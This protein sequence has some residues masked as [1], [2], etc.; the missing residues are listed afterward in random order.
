MF[1]IH[2]IKLFLA[3]VL[4]GGALVAGRVVAVNLPPF[5]TT[6]IRFSAVSLF[7]VPVLYFRR[8]SFPRPSKKAAILL[9][10]L[11]FTGVLLF[12]F[13]LFSGLRTVTAVR[14]SVIIAFTPAVVALV[15][16]LFF[17]EKIRP[18]MGLGILAAFIGAVITIT[19]GELQ[20]IF[21]RALSV[22]DLF[23]LGCVF[24]WTIYS[25]TAKYAMAELAPLTVLT[26][27]SVIG[28]VLL[29]PFALT[30]G[31]LVDLGS[32]PPETWISLLYLS[33]GA[34]GIA[35]LFYYEGIQA[36]GASRSAIFLNLEPVAAISLGMLILDEELSLA[37]ALGAVLVI[38]GLFLTNYQKR[39]S[40]TA[41]SKLRTT[42]Q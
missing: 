24:T 22:G 7:L 19:E 5:T 20:L 3:P 18:L 28:A 40:P 16:G 14:S 13:F 32:Q 2:Y 6:F 8:G 11:S 27:G 9:V 21:S 34:A 29:I 37:V 42:E 4:W 26:Y 38:G 1:Q 12:N 15:S 30:E 35:Y 31:A 33:I 41:E 39:S 10:A 36:V 23:L 17:R 25:I